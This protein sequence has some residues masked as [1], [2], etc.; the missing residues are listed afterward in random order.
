M[1]NSMYIAF[2]KSD[3]QVHCTLCVSFLQDLK[4][5]QKLMGFKSLEMPVH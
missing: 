4:Q 1:H 3:S 2:S 5:V